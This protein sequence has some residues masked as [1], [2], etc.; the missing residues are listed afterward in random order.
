[1]GCDR[2]CFLLWVAKKSESAKPSP[3][4]TKKTVFPTIFTLAGSRAPPYLRCSCTS[5][6]TCVW[7]QKT[8]I[9]VSVFQGQHPLVSTL[10]LPL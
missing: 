2:K 3:S 7:N 1:M 8:S 4:V 10:G 6:W 5:G 9:V